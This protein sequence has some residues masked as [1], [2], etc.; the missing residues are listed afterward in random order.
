MGK[1]NIYND[2][3]KKNYGLAI[4]EI[5]EIRLK[6]SDINLINYCDELIKLCNNDSDITLRDI[7]IDY[8][9]IKD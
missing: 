9:L 3:Y 2:I 4:S 5:N 8:I 1:V 7:L 6:T